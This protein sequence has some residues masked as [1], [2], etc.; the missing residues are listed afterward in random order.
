MILWAL[1]LSN[2]DFL[3]HNNLFNFVNNFA[4]ALLIAVDRTGD[5]VSYPWSINTEEVNCSVQSR[6]EDLDQSSGGPVPVISPGRG[7]R[8][9]HE[10][11]RFMKG[12]IIKHKKNSFTLCKP[13]IWTSFKFYFTKLRNPWVRENISPL[14]RKECSLDSHIDECSSHSPLQ[15]FKWN[16]YNRY[17]KF[18]DLGRI[19]TLVILRVNR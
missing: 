9:N 1:Y 16:S 5:E 2:N 17:V 12:V 10:R 4:L 14:L 19:S 3:N 11:A 8:Q 7:P 18:S 6:R 13:N 15:I